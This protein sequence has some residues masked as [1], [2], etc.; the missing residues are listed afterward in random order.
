MKK[1]VI[2][3]AIE[4]VLYCFASLAMW[5]LFVA[6]LQ[7]IGSEFAMIKYAAP[8][9]LLCLT[10]IYSLFVF[11]LFVRPRSKEGLVKCSKINGIILGVLGLAIIGLSVA[12]I[13]SGQ[14]G[15]IVTG[16]ISALFPLD[17][18]LLGL[19]FAGAGVLCFLSSRLFDFDELT[20]VEKPKSKVWDI[21]MHIL[22]PIYTLVALFFFG[23]I[24]YFFYMF[25]YSFVNFLPM[26]VVY[27]MCLIPTVWAA[28]Y[29]W[30]YSSKEDEIAKQLLGLKLSYVAL[31]VNILATALLILA[32]FVNPLFIAESGTALFPGDFMISIQFGPIFL[33]IAA[34]VTPIV[35]FSKNVKMDKKEKELAEEE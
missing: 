22:I 11:H 15:S 24:L 1:K 35:A 28:I 27:A 12:G 20:Y 23:D 26:L 14:Y 5:H 9:Y 32:I 29:E 6:L 10:T 4:A 25:D 3:Y 8:H 7:D 33:S 18:M 21:F 13:A 16:G 31:G 17:H 19:L 30:W 2:F 34:I